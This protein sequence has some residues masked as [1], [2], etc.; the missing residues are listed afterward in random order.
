MSRYQRA[1]HTKSHPSRVPLAVS[2]LLRTLALLSA[3]SANAVLPGP[4]RADEHEP[5]RAR[6][7]VY[8]ESNDPAGNAVF[9]FARDDNGRLTPL[10]GSPYPTGGLGITPTFALGPFDSDQ[11][12]IVDP[13]G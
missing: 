6:N 3:W 8:V 13:S 5:A 9:G 12:V 2:M 7:I 10:P 4:A 1:A 11:N